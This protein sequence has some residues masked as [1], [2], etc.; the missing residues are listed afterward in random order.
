MHYP[1]HQIRGYCLYLGSLSYN[2]HCL[3]MG[4]YEHPDGTV[5]HAIV[6]GEEDHEYMSG[7]I[8]F[9]NPKYNFLGMRYQINR[10]LYEDYLKRINT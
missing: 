10:L 8:D 2:N 7:E 3:D 9:D 6:Y 1:Q 5:S 4:V